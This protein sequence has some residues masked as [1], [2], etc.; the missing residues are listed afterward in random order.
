MVEVYVR[1]R[2]TPVSGEELRDEY[3]RQK[4]YRRRQAEVAALLVRLW[5]LRHEREYGYPAR[6]IEPPNKWDELRALVNRLIAEEE[7]R[8]EPRSS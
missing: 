6:T 1:E 8:R 5:R 7:A 2:G 4:D 3:R